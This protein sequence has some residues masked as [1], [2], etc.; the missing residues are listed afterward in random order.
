MKSLTVKSSELYSNYQMAVR[1][2]LRQPALLSN[3]LRRNA[4]DGK[5]WG[6]FGEHIRYACLSLD[7]KG[8]SS[9]G[10]CFA[11]L[12]NLNIEHRASILERNSYEFVESAPSQ[13]SPLGFRSSW[14]NRHM[15]AVAKCANL[16]TSG[17]RQED[18]P[19]ILMETGSS[20]HDDEFIEVH[21]FG[22]FDFKAFESIGTSG[23][24]TDPRDKLTLKIIEQKATAEGKTWLS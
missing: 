3:D 9:Y 21:I 10:D 20:R 2:R 4:V 15:V 24:V 14:Q 19:G 22:P 12:K 6:S 7:G 1:A 16:V 5:L 8:L 13:P 11:V 23:K 17:T 18:F